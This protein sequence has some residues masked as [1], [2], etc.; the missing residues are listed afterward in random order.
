[1]L[2]STI[3]CLCAS[4]LKILA[5]W[6]LSTKLSINRI[7]F[8]FDTIKRI[9]WSLYPLNCYKF[10]SSS[11]LLILFSSLKKC[12][13]MLTLCMLQTF[14]SVWS[15]L[16]L[17]P[18]KANIGYFPIICKQACNLMPK[19]FVFLLPNIFLFSKYR[20]VRICLYFEN[21]KMLF[22]I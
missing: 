8:Q 13:R 4:V 9:S 15:K 22:N 14:P 2:D 6:L 11:M 12:N 10:C 20:H 19:V 5:H 16:S 7:L 21:R 17:L 18:T 3:L 1:M